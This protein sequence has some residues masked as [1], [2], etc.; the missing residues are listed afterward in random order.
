MTELSRV[1]LGSRGRSPLA[2]AV[3]RRVTA[4]RLYAWE[5]SAIIT[6][7][8]SQEKASTRG[9][10]NLRSVRGS[11]TKKREMAGI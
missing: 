5:E 6:I 1:L 8:V 2:D 3:T 10:K 7:A 9:P 11:D 4:S